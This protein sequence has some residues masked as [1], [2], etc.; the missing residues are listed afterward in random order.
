[1]TKL[2]QVELMNETRI[3]SLKKVG[4]N[5][6][7]NE[8]IRKIFQDEACFFKMKKE[9]AYMILR[10]IGIS[11]HIDEIYAGLISKEEYY[12][13]QQKGKIKE[14]ELIIKYEAYH[15]ADLF[16]KRK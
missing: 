11:S 8:V 7:R 4:G 2:K 12:S 1:M 15:Q 6:Q 10:D 3:A 16:Q 14:D 9:D 5:S 13:L